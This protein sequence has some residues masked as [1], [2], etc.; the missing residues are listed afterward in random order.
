MLADYADP[1]FS[2][3]GTE[4]V[5]AYLLSGFVGG[6]FTIKGGK[7]ES[8]AATWL[9]C[10]AFGPLICFVL[11]LMIL[12][13]LPFGLLAAALGIESSDSDSRGV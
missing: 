11:L 2:A 4:F 10:T 6:F 13:I 3:Y 5:V 9:M 8:P 12:P 7:C 1:F